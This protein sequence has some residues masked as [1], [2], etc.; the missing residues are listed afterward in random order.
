M[1]RWYGDLVMRHAL[2]A[3][4]LGILAIRIFKHWGIPVERII[5][6]PYTVAVIDHDTSPA[7]DDKNF[8]SGRNAFVYIGSQCHRKATNIL[9]K[10]FASI[11]EIIRREWA[12]MLVDKDMTKGQY[13]NMARRLKNN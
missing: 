13:T 3:F 7:H 10:A 11:H 5:F 6:L 2:G 4:A 12:L 1:K 8:L 9:L